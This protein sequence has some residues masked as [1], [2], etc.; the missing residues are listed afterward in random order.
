MIGTLLSRW[1]GRKSA[2]RCRTKFASWDDGSLIQKFF[3][4]W[5]S[6]LLESCNCSVWHLSRV[7]DYNR[8][9]SHRSTRQKLQELCKPA[10]EKD[11]LYPNGTTCWSYSGW[12]RSQMHSCRACSLSFLP[13]MESVNPSQAWHCFLIDFWALQILSETLNRYYAF[14]Q[15]RRPVCSNETFLSLQTFLGY[16]VRHAR[17]FSAVAKHSQNLVQT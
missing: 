12:Y 15:G 14:E 2:S 17:F 5:D 1:L 9:I 7:P 13:P 11:C 16:R 4:S 10:C 6:Q 8:F 3:L